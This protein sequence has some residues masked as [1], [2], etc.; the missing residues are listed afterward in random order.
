MAVV[1][2]LNAFVKTP[3]IVHLKLMDFIVHKL[4]LTKIDPQ[5]NSI[6]KITL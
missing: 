2:Q 1:A 5:K 6:K 4:H 3:Q